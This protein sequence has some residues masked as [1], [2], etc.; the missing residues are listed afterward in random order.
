M[1]KGP[2]AQH[3]LFEFA[4]VPPK[5]DYDLEVITWL[6]ALYETAQPEEAEGQVAA[7]TAEQ[8][9]RLLDLYHSFSE[10]ATPMLF[11]PETIL[12]LERLANDPDSVLNHWSQR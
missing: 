2:G 1:S 3:A 6:L 4:G 9:E 11:Q 12:L 10:D 5:P 7:F 8:S